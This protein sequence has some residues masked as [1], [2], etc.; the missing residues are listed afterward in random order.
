MECNHGSEHLFK[1]YM[2]KPSRRKKNLCLGYVYIVNLD[3]AMMTLSFGANID[4]YDTVRS[5]DVMKQ[6]GLGP[7]GGILTSLKGEDFF[8]TKNVLLHHIPIPNRI[9]DINIGPEWQYQHR[10]VKVNDNTYL[11]QRFFNFSM[12]SIGA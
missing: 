2:Q 6:Y 5:M 7:N 1:L 3:P 8:G 10:M 4:I 11:K 9:T 12:V